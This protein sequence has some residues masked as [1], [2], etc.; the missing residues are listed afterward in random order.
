MKVGNNEITSQEHIKYLGIQLD[1]N[2]KIGVHVRITAEKTTKALTKVGKLIANIGGPKEGIRRAL[3]SVVQS[4]VMHALPI[5]EGTLQKK[6][7]RA[8]LTSL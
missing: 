4:I 3:A 7:N 6:N 1:V 2:M 8:V 5:W